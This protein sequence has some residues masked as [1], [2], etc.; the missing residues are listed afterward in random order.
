MKWIALVFLG[1]GLLACQE[2]KD[3]RSWKPAT[4]LPAETVAVARFLLEHGLADPEGGTYREATIEI[5]SVWRGDKHPLKVNAFQ[6]GKTNRVVA[7]N[8]LS[9]EAKSLGKEVDLAA[10]IRS[11]IVKEVAMVDTGF[12]GNS[13][14]QRAG[15]ANHVT[16]ALLLL[17]FGRSDLAEEVYK[18][19]GRSVTTPYSGQ[20]GDPWFRPAIQ[21]L[22]NRYDRALAAHMRGDDQ[23]ALEDFK[24]LSE[25]YQ[26]FVAE[27]DKRLTAGFKRQLSEPGYT[28]PIAFIAPVAALYD[29]SK[30]RVGRSESAIDIKALSSKPQSERVAQLIQAMSQ[31]SERQWGQPGSVSIGSSPIVAALVAEGDAAV[32]PLLTCMEGDKRFTR[33]VSF[34]RDFAIQRNPITV[35]ACARVALNSILGVNTSGNPGP[36]WSNEQVRKYW[37]VNKGT[38]VQERWY[39]DL[40]NDSASYQAWELA[41]RNI[42]ERTDIVRNGDWIQRPKRAPGQMLP[43]MKGESLRIG[44]NPTVTN[45]FHRRATELMGTGEVRSTIDIWRGQA[46]ASIAIASYTWDPKASLKTLQDVSKGA[47]KLV[48]AQGSHAT[49]GLIGRTAKI[50]SAR[51]ALGDAAAADEYSELLLS[52]I[53]KAEDDYAREVGAL[54]V[55]WE[56]PNEP[57]L[58]ELAQKIFTT[59]GSPW[60]VL[61]SV[62]SGN[63]YYSRQMI[64]EPVLLVPEFRAAIAKAIL[65]PTLFGEGKIEKQGKNFTFRYSGKNGGSGGYG[66]QGLVPARMVGVTFPFRASD[67]LILMMQG[68][69]GIPNFEIY[70]PEAQRQKVRLEIARYLV[71]DADFAGLINEYTWLKYRDQ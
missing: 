64:K 26:A 4:K 11:K 21:Y 67:S 43:P 48:H 34:G 50:Y 14:G 40:T 39:R 55:L 36:Y 62:Q 46:G 31:I 29:D 5:G 42:T 28:H 65:D 3:L 47:T 70:W 16:G 33:S 63:T 59:E 38:T 35:A 57:R 10:D 56:H 37:E 58:K 23:S 71:G 54:R 60:N 69:K 25:N 22:S 61:G 18:S 49:S 68:M 51:L 15:S 13:E 19:L 2:Q 66:I 52:L 32:E 6:I 27:A 53:G 9:Y 8:G 44:Q 12:R 30:N 7:W 1:F 24:V 20:S 17:R 41:A 45:L